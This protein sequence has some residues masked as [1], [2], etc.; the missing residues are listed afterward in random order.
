MPQFERR[1]VA[2]YCLSMWPAGGYQLNFPLGPIPEYSSKQLGYE[3]AARYWRPYR[4]EIDAI[5]FFDT[6]IVLIETKVIKAWHV[7]GQLLLYK[8]LVPY[9]EKLKAWWGKDIQLRIVMPER[10]PLA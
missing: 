8:E 2:E 7:L 9:T 1:Y 5:K 4:P 10:Q 6:G 3:A